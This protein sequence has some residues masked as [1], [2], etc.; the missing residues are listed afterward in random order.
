M[1]S[2][3][4][5]RPSGY[6]SPASPYSNEVGGLVLWLEELYLRESARGLGLGSEAMEYVK[7]KKTARQMSNACGWK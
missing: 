3:D 2:K 6:C 1:L 7:K 5:Q 4:E